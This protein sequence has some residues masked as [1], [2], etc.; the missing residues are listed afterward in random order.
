MSKIVDVGC[1]PKF[2]AKLIKDGTN[3][4][5]DV[6]DILSILVVTKPPTHK[7]EELAMLGYYEESRVLISKYDDEANVLVIRFKI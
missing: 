1:H 6:S 5:E 2:Q 7:K 4:K 3:D